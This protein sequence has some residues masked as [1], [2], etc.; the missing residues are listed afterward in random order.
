MDADAIYR[1][2]QVPLPISEVYVFN[3]FRRTTA[4]RNDSEARHT[5]PNITLPIIIK[6]DTA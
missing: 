6:P 5:A 1:I 4:E 2:Y 3:L